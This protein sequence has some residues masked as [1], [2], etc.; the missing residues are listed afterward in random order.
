MIGLVGKRPPEIAGNPQAL[1]MYQDTIPTQNNS[2]D[3]S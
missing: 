3:T 1:N 2:T